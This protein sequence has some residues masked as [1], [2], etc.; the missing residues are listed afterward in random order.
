M[1]Q[2]RAGGC[3]DANRQR[4]PWRG[5]ACQETQP[6]GACAWEGSAARCIASPQGIWPCAWLADVLQEEPN[7]YLLCGHLYVRQ[8]KAQATLMTA[9]LARSEAA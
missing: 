4:G 7:V 3:E 6:P 8:G 9:S 2:R 1:T 5:Q